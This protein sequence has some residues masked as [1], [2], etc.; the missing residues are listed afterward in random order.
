MIASP[1]SLFS[2]LAPS[3]SILTR[4]QKIKTSVADDSISSR[5]KLVDTLK[6]KKMIIIVS[7]SGVKIGTIRVIIT[8]YYLQISERS[9]RSASKVQGFHLK[10]NSLLQIDTSIIH[11]EIFGHDKDFFDLNCLRKNIYICV[12]YVLFYSS[13]ENMCGIRA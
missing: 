10:N 9:I 4:V 11:F 12:N 5:R 3:S 8:I 7:L 13:C 1:C 6:N 2:S